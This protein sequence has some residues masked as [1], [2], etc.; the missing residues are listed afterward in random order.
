MA[1]EEN[2]NIVSLMDESGTEEEFEVVAT[3]NLNEKDY[4]ILLPLEGEEEA[5]YIFRI[6]RDENDKDILVPIEDD[7][8][9]EAVREEFEQFIQEEE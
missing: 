3:L 7:D 4:A 5:G 6:D 2:E 9:F 8:E 1:N